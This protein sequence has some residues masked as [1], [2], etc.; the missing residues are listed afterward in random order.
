MIH[1]TTKKIIQKLNITEVEFL[2]FKLFYNE[3]YLLY[4]NEIYDDIQTKIVHVENYLDNSW[5]NN[6]FYYLKRKH[7]DFD[8]IVDLGFSIPYLYFGSLQSL[9]S[10]SEK[11]IVLVDNLCSIEFARLLVSQRTYPLLRFVQGDITKSNT[12]KR[13]GR[14]DDS[15]KLLFTAFEVIE[16]LKYDHIF[17]NHIKKHVNASLILSIPIGP[18]IPAHYKE[19]KTETEVILYLQQYVK[20]KHFRIF[21]NKNSLFRIF[22]A[23]TTIY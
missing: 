6:R 10:I 21:K 3:C 19:F 1:E 14:Y 20:I 7:R 17:W 12:W 23:I 15:S 4:G 9:I 18:K 16:H 5:W 8:K 13:I 11:Q 2:Q 22:T